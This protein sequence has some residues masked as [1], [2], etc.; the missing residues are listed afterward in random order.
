MKKNL[1]LLLALVAMCVT[2]YAQPSA[3]SVEIPGT[4]ETIVVDGFADDALWSTEIDP[5]PFPY[6]YQ[7]E[8]ADPADLDATIQLA[9]N[10]LG[11]LIFIDI[12][13]DQENYFAEGENSWEQDNC[14]FFYYFGDEGT[15]GADAEVT[16]VAGDSL[17]SQ[18]R[19]QMTDDYITRTDGR[20]RGEWVSA[21]FGPADLDSMEAM[22]VTSGFGWSLEVIFPWN[23]FA[24]T[25]PAA[26]GL[27]F[28]FDVSVGDADEALRDNQLTLLN[29]SKTDNAWDNKSFLNTAEL[30]E[31]PTNI[32]NHLVNRVSVYPTLVDNL[33]HVTGKV[34]SATIYNVTG[35]PVLSIKDNN[36]ATIDVSAL[37]AGIYFISLNNVT[38]LFFI[39][40]P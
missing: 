4:T 28:G 17:F 20:F 39:L 34:S 26:E 1:L 22:A 29:D 7:E 19:I 5:Q 31:M 25:Y 12:T 13:D 21:P 30:G 27:K 9:W 2:I 35:Q 24:M 16:A 38:S 6:T 32:T 33:L 14:E 18:I 40:L 11:L 37:K 36:I 15:W 8:R 10:E 3:L 23:M